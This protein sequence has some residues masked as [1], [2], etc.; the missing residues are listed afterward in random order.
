MPEAASRASRGRLPLQQ[1][2]EDVIGL[3]ALG[4]GVEVQQD[5]V[6]KNRRGQRGHVVVGNMIAALHERPRLRAQYQEL[7][8]A[9]AG[10]VVYVLVYEVRSI[11]VRAAGGPY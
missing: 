9:H 4:F 7:R 11:P 2:T 10:P 1:H 6:T 3:Q 8:R 5:P